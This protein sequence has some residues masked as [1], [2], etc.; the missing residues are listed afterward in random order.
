MY[1]N[2]WLY[3]QS[4]VFICFS[5]NIEAP[6]EIHLFVCLIDFLHVLNK[7]KMANSRIQQKLNI[8]SKGKNIDSQVS[9]IC[10]SDIKLED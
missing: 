4:K 7:K 8:D 5:G 9:I 6:V 10:Q 1:K 2:Q 3:I